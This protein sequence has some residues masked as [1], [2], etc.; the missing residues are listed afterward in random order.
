MVE[1]I[2]VYSRMSQESYPNYAR[3]RP[4]PTR[5]LESLYRSHPCVHLLPEMTSH[6]KRDFQNCSQ[7][8]SQFLSNLKVNRL[9]T[10]VGRGSHCS[11]PL[12][13]QR[14]SSWSCGVEASWC[15][16]PQAGQHRRRQQSGHPVPVKNSYSA[17]AF[18]AVNAS[19][20]VPPASYS[21]LIRIQLTD[22]G[23]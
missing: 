21:P 22:Y 23:R 3:K 6:H 13:P 16:S 20:C 5:D 17:G 7:L 10:A 12:A 1:R 8:L 9:G 4:C 15:M 14:G 2:K 11:S 19:R 18:A